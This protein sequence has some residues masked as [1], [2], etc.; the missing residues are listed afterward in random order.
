MPKKPIILS[1]Y[2]Y[3]NILD[4]LE[5]VNYCYCKPTEFLIEE[6]KEGSKKY[7]ILDLL[8]NVKLFFVARNE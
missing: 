8:T 6:Q 1:I 5:N 7:I 2:H 4:I 3:H